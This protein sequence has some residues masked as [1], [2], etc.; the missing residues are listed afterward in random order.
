[1]HSPDHY[2]R[3]AQNTFASHTIDRLTPQR[4]DRD[5]LAARLEDPQTCLVPVWQ[6]RNFVSW[7]N[8]PQPVFLSPEAGA[9]YA[10]D[11]E[12]LT[13]LG[14]VE[15]QIYFAL[16]VGGERN[17]PPPGL[18][19]LGRF[20]NL[21]NIG[22][23]LESLAATLLASAKAMVYW[24]RR[25]RFCG[26]CGHPTQSREGGYVRQCRNPDC[27]QKH[28]PRTDPAI[29]VL[30]QSGE[31]ALL[32]RQPHWPAGQYSTIAGFVEP[33]ETL[34]AAVIR[35]VDE[36]TGVQVSRMTYH[37][38]QPWPF[39]SS[40]MLGYMAEARTRAI[41]LNDHELQHARWISR[42]E[43]AAALR[44]KRMRLPPPISISHRLIE[45]WFNVG[46]EGPLQALV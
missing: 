16:D 11:V 31:E 19:T 14:Q 42:A 6:D 24:H 29:I 43:L 12:A 37:S 5:W 26:D 39:P 44:D 30:V 1:M 3:S 46:N 20:E 41:R 18:A 21:R 33:G 4:S 35:E 34:E 7:V 45:T 13:L 27:G 10:A 38:S 15:D 22:L 2:A 17:A 8:P 36:E 23:D 32:G 9:P 25:H 28:F 40:L